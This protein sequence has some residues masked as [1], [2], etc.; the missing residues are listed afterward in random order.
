MMQVGTLALKY[1]SGLKYDP[2]A[3]DVKM[4]IKIDS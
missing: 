1:M 2:M 3:V 4:D